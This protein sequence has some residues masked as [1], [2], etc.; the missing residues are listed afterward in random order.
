MKKKVLLL[1]SGGTI[2]MKESEQGYVPD[3]DFV[4]KVKQLPELQHESMPEIEIFCLTP[5]LDSANMTPA[6][7]DRIVAGIQRY[8]REYDGFILLHGTDTMAYTASALT[9]MLE[10]FHKPLMITGAQV[11]LL[12]I[13]NDAR[14]N[15]ISSLLI[16]GNYGE[17]ISGVVTVYF[18]NKLMLGCRTVKVNA[19]HFD[20]FDSP[21]FP[22]LAQIGVKI[23][24]KRIQSDV[25]FHPQQLDGSAPT[26]SEPKNYSLEEDS[27][28]HQLEF[29]KRRG[30][31]E[32]GVLR[33]FPGISA[34]YIASVLQSG[35]LKGLVLEA[36]GVGNGPTAAAQPDLFRVLKAATDRGL[37]IVAVTQCLKGSVL[38]DEYEASLKHAG[39]LSGYDMSTEAALAKLYYLFSKREYSL[40]D[41]KRKISENLRGELTLPD[42]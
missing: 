6:D 32:V 38:L 37:L 1:Y 9:F 29:E 42:K 26:G 15:L 8:Y 4:M 19:T 40:T 14:D 18:D 21:N 24:I 13:R 20:A 25:V 33:L 28:F 34:E 30:E 36:Y 22:L 2:G 17:K 27:V 12:E 35:R 10:K 3:P 41:V 5:L 31:L 7:W 11:P 16:C 39:I 23:G